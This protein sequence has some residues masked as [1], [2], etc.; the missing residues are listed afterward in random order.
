MAPLLPPDPL[1]LL[2]PPL[3]LVPPVPSEPASDVGAELSDEHAAIGTEAAD[4]E[5][6]SVAR[7]SFL[8]ITDFLSAAGDGSS[9]YSL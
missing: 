4:A 5:R 9:V 6:S 3:L 8:D 2:L 1:L 7:V